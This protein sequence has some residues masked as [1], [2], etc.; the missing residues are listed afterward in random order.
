MLGSALGFS[1]I[2][3]AWAFLSLCFFVAF[4]LY[5]V[6]S[7]LPQKYKDSLV[8]V[9]F[10]D[11]IRYG[12]TKQSLKRDDCLRLFDVPKRWFWHFY[13]VSLCWSAC[14]LFVNI[15]C[16]LQDQ[17]LPSW[18]TQ[19]LAIFTDSTATNAD[20]PQTFP[21]LLLLLCAHSSRR[22]IECCFVSIFSDGVI[23]VVQYI[24]GLTYYILLGFTALSSEY[25]GQRAD[26]VAL[27]QF[28]W[29]HA[30]GCALFVVASVLQHQSL[31][32]LARLRTGP[33]GNIETTAHK[34]P[35]GGHFELVSCPHYFAELL[36]YVSLFVVS[37]FSFTWRLVVLYVFFNQAL[38]AQLSHDLYTTKYDSYPTQRKAFIP[39]VL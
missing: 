13:A 10:Q 19:I 25:S 7:R 32:L 2:D 8:C 20:V 35:R 37:G 24:F 14:L 28:T 36:I 33:S 3:A 9:V 1:V 21:L 11:L 12:K 4:V 29:S 18:L 6:S 38:A 27:L 16:I 39:F 5:K 34:P 26:D 22:L 23:H 15:K 30:A 31:V 17:P